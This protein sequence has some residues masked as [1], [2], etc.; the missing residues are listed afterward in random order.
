[1][2]YN[3]RAPSTVTDEKYR[4]VPAEYCN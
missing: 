2:H 4:R 1:V 3:G